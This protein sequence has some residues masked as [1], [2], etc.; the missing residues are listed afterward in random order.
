MLSYRDR[1]IDFALPLYRVSPRWTCGGPL[2]DV[3]KGLFQYVHNGA[4]RQLP[5][6]EVGEII[7]FVPSRF[8]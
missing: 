8:L 7:I 5:Q 4:T 3:V 1:D 2:V 6:K